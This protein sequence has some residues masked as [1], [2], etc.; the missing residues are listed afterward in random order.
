MQPEMREFLDHARFHAAAVAE[1]AQMLPADDA[2]LS[3]MI[4]TAVR[5]SDLKTFMFVML[6]ALHAE[7]KLDARLLAH[8]VALM[9]HADWIGAAAFHMVG[10]VAEHLMDAVRHKRL[11]DDLASQTLFIVAAWCQEQRGGVLPDDL[12]TLARLQARVKKMG[13]EAYSLLLAVA[14]QAN[15]A[16]LQQILRARADGIVKKRDGSVECLPGVRGVNN[17]L[18]QFFQDQAVELRQISLKSYRR[19]I[20]EMAQ[21]K[22]SGDLDATVPLRRA[23]ARTGRNEPCPCGSGKKYKHCCLEKDHE[24]LLHSSPVAGRT[25]EEVM[26]E[27]EPH[28]TKV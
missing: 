22:P 15:D 10:D 2:E 23:V 1:L 25:Q 5:E 26:V 19:S 7:R 16:G 18:W 21:D 20:L 27:P 12:I 13:V 17:E 24:R 4:E 28:L 6:A 11:P 3:A 8:G 9:P 14:L